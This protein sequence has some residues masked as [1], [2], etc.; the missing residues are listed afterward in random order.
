MR[1]TARSFRVIGTI[2]LALRAGHLARC[3][4]DR[5]GAGA[6]RPR[7]LQRRRRIP[8]VQ[9]RTYKFSETNE[10]MKFAL[11]VSSKVAKDK[12]APLIVALHGLGG[13]GNS[14]LRGASLELAEA[15]GYILVG[16]MGYNPSGSFRPAQRVIVMGGRGRGRGGPPGAAGTAG[17][18]G[19]A[20]PGRA[21][22]TSHPERLAEL[23]ELDIRTVIKMIR[24]E[25]T[26]DDDRTYLIGPLD[27][28]RRCAV[29]R[30]E[31]RE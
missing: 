27:G 29:P 8:R 4:R 16:P 24:E 5:D 3:G 22:S 15:G 2:G 10:E 25:F 19:G 9:Q 26:V 30:S 7:R 31:V 18:P 20:R 12:K 23:S 11:F 1:E 6:G 17:A 13:D 14:L 28:R 21:L